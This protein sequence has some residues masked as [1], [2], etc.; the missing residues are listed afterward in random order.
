MSYAAPP[1]LLTGLRS[2]DEWND[3][4]C[5]ICARWFP[6]FDRLARHM[7]ARHGAPTPN[8]PGMVELPSRRGSR[9]RSHM[10]KSKNVGQPTSAKPS[11]SNAIPAPSENAAGEYNP[12]LKAADVGKLNESAVLVLM[13]K[14][15][16]ADGGFGEQIVCE[17]K[18]KGKVYD[19]PIKID[20]V[21]HRL[22]FD[23]FGANP[24]KWVGKVKVEIKEFNRNNY[25]AVERS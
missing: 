7:A 6:T 4:D 9:K 23:R 11:R 18:Y 1:D 21:N 24:A 22:L 8:D 10:A 3:L 5:V 15:R 16:M 13:G 17:T 20:S 14:S 19:W 12:F 25:I 2:R